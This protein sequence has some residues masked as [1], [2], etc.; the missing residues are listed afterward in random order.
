MAGGYMNERCREILDILLKSENYLSLQKIAD[1][2][3]EILEEL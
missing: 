1:I 2:S 3:N